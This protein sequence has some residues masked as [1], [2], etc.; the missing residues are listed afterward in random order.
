MSITITATM[1]SFADAEALVKYLSDDRI[2]PDA[3]SMCCENGFRVSA[4]VGV[5][6][7]GVA[8]SYF[9]DFQERKGSKGNG[10]V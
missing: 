2:L 8:S 9:R 4:E 5:R 7:M 10:D 1:D 3:V 6:E